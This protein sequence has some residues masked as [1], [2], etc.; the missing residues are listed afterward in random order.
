MA[1]EKMRLLSITGNNEK[2]DYIIAKYL[3][4]SGIQLENAPKVLE[5]GWK[6]TYFSYN[7]DIRDLTRKTENVLKALDISFEPKD[8]E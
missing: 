3:L 1:I 7:S 8:I 6:L 5:K 4:K 2:L